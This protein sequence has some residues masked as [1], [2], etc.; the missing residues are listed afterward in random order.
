M[1]PWQCIPSDPVS[2]TR[3]SYSQSHY[4]RTDPAPT[5]FRSHWAHIVSVPLL[6]A[7][8]HSLG[9]ELIRKASKY[10]ENL[11]NNLETPLKPSKTHEKHGIT[12]ETIETVQKPWDYLEELWQP[13]QSH[14]WLRKHY[15]GNSRWITGSWVTRNWCQQM[16]F[17]QLCLLPIELDPPPPI[18]QLYLKWGNQVKIRF[19]RSCWLGG[20]I[21]LKPMRLNCILQDLFRVPPTWPY[22][23]YSNTR[24]W[25]FL[26]A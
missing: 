1:M 15:F 26:R 11:W 7:L 8:F 10:H 19:G 2:S 4:P 17:S 12:M 14:E 18:P 16:R 23:A 20:P 21:G 13:T 25:L 5:H 22:L 3:S 24:I 9:Q 6:D